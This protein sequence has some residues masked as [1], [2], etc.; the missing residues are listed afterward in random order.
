MKKNILTLVT[1]L[2]LAACHNE[3]NTNPTSETKVAEEVAKKAEIETAKLAEDEAAKAAEAEKPG[4]LKIMPFGLPMAP[5]TRVF[6]F[7][8]GQY[9]VGDMYEANGVLATKG[10]PKD[11]VDFYEKA[12]A[13]MGFKIFSKSNNVDKPG[14]AAKR[15][16]TGDYIT[17]SAISRSRDKFDLEIDE[18]GLRVLFRIP[19]LNRNK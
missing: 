16:N 9:F 11:V 1:V 8:I 10:N 19:S 13:D 17:L 14:F 15:K 7:G 5:D 6:G 18:T 3:A 2:A 12:L 4:D